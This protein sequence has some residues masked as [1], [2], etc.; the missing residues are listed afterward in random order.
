MHRASE[1]EKEAEQE[2]PPS[3]ACSNFIMQCMKQ[4]ITKWGSDST[5]GPVHTFV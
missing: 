5:A 2:N 4:E 3:L 1:K